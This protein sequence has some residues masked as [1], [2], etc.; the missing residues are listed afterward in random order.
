MGFLHAS[1]SLISGFCPLH[2]V[3][4]PR[5]NWK[6]LRSHLST[7]IF[8]DCRE[9]LRT[10]SRD[11]EPSGKEWK[12]CISMLHIGL[13]VS[14]Q[15]FIS[16]KVI[17]MS[18]WR[19]CHSDAVRY[20]LCQWFWTK[21]GEAWTNKH[22]FQGTLWCQLLSKRARCRPGDISSF[23]ATN[24]EHGCNPLSIP[25]CS[26]FPPWQTNYPPWMD[27]FFQRCIQDLMSSGPRGSLRYFSLQSS[28]GN[29]TKDY[30]R[31]QQRPCFLPG[32]NPSWALTRFSKKVPY[33]CNNIQQ[34][35]YNW[36][37]L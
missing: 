29:Q 10:C 25:N 3:W 36:H 26:I 1:A 24:M 14:R 37:L 11:F 21:P 6:S 2:F 4:K 22:V 33:S 5:P 15:S 23:S 32:E 30:I 18:L 13:L 12:T 19:L 20:Y 8:R 17:L 27:E 34:P 7:V 31:R 9:C 28:G 16:V 35:V